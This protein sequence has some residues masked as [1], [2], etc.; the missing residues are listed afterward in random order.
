MTR[1][2]TAIVPA[3]VLLGSPASAQEWQQYMTHEDD[4]VTTFPGEPE[5]REITWDSEYGA[6]LPGRVYS[7]DRNG[8]HYSVT[9]IDY[10]NVREAHLARTNSTEADS[11]ENYEYWR[12]DKLASIAYAATQFRQRG[13]EVT[14]DAWHHIDRVAGHQLQI[15]NPDTS[16]TYAG[17]YLHQDRLYIIEANVPRGAPPPGM[18]QQSLRFIDENGRPIRY[19]WDENE[20]LVRDR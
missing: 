1:H 2:L 15:T 10:T 11:P 6:V 3:L 14:F 19:N 7:A 9:V 4:F 12:I 18:F 5:V 8:A 16:R 13:G 20:Q 17:I